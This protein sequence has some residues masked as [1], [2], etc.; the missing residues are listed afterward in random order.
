MQGLDH[1]CV[2]LF[3]ALDSVLKVENVRI[4][5]TSEYCIAE[6]VTKR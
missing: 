2:V 3:G 5:V 1:V 6:K 4:S